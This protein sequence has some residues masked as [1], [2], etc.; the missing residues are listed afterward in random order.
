MA[1]ID[2]KNSY[3]F[4][5]ACLTIRSNCSIMNSFNHSNFSSSKVSYYKIHTYEL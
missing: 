2:I 3:I 1:I 5:I 4:K